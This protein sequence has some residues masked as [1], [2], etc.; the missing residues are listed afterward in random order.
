[1]G[2]TLSAAL[3]ACLIAA[4]AQPLAASAAVLVPPIWVG[5]LPPPP[6]T[7]TR[8]TKMYGT[9]TFDHAAHLARRVSCKGCHG[10]GKVGEI[11]FTPRLAHDRCRNCHLENGRG[12]T[13]CNGCHTK[14]AE[15]LAQAGSGPA[16]L[17]PPPPSRAE[18]LAAIEPAVPPTAFHRTFELGLTTLVANGDVL[19]GPAM[20]LVLAYGETAIAYSLAIPGGVTN[21][22]MQL[23]V[24]GGRYFGLSRRVRWCA[25]GVGGLDLSF[26]PNAFVPA[27]GLRAGLELATPGRVLGSVS[28]QL[29]ALADLASNADAGR[30][31]GDVSVGVAL[32]AGSR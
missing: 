15:A 22:R 30:H 21:G 16:A 1:M 19:Y 23:L 12:P 8:E 13:A 27:V 4:A 6:Q 24:G 10:Q 9:V 29:T 26:D 11:A 5:A 3:G 28:L 2:R 18:Q 7:V 31:A 17:S 32:V 25:L 14:P 20:N